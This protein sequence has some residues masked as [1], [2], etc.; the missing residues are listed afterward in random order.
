MLAG[1]AGIVGIQ[2]S[3]T[4]DAVYDD[5]YAGDA[6]AITE[7]RAELVP[8]LLVFHVSTMLACVLV[9]VFAAGLRR[10]LAAQAPVGSL[11][12]D[13]SAAGLLLVSV[14]ALMGTGLDTEFIFAAQDTEKVVAESMAFDAHWT[15]TVNFLWVGAG[16]TGVA[17]AAAALRHAAAPRWIGWVGAGARRAHPAAGDLPAAVHGRLHRPGAAARR[18]RRVRPG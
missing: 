8:N 16:V 15:G 2:A 3:M 7:R 13:L 10:R 14:A 1:V 17:L 12:P 18:G 6:D 11:L 4:L 5:T 9:L